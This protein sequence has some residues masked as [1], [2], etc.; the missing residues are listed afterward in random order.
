[1][2]ATTLCVFVFVGPCAVLSCLLFGIWPLVAPASENGRHLNGGRCCFFLLLFAAW[3]FC[4]E[5][6]FEFYFW[7]HV[8]N[9][10]EMVSMR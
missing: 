1:M 6:L 4:G 3:N 9:V 5:D 10:F 7:G 8:L 2:E